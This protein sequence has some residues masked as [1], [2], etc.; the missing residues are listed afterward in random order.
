MTRRSGITVA[1][2]ALV[3]LG[4][5]ACG[6]RS[7]SVPEVPAEE[8]SAQLA[9]LDGIHEIMRP[10][11]HDAFP[12]RDFDAIREMAPQFEEKLVALDAVQLPGILRDKQEGWDAGKQRL[13]ETYR[14]FMAAVESGNE[15]EMLGLT[16][17][18]H[19]TYEG[20][21]RVIRPVVPEL[22]VFHQHLYGLYHY[23]G[24]GYDLEK[25][26]IATA[27]LAESVGPL[28]AAELPARVADRQAQ[29]L[30]AV[31]SLAREVTTLQ[32]ALVD[33][34]RAT[35]EGAIEAVHTAYTIVEQVF[36]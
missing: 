26:R 23:Y 33:P 36:N 3:T 2:L 25:I 31:S 7:G 29:F 10:L 9:E 5:S 21:V 32:D 35:V 20:L 12:A 15:E 19:M 24:P 28:Q 13:M 6:Q 16:E 27:D 11:W 18:F 34:N 30:D 22:E 17:T 14:G 1:A 8:L 4:L